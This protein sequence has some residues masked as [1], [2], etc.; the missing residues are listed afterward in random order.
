MD[1]CTIFFY[2]K[3]I[4]L[5]SLLTKNI[6]SPKSTLWPRDCDSNL[7]TQFPIGQKHSA[8]FVTQFGI[9]QEE[10]VTRLLIGHLC[11]TVFDCCLS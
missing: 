8:I 10:F 3:E 1:T 4:Q 6:A 9:G 2:S 5:I 7:A 11:T